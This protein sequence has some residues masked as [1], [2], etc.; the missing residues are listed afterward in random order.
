MNLNPVKDLGCN[1]WNWDLQVCL[2][3][4]ERYVFNSQGLCTPL[5]PNCRTFNTNNSCLECYKGYKISGT[6]CV[7]DEKINLPATDVGCAQWNWDSQIC[8]KC[9]VR[10][11]MNSR[12]QCIK[13]QD[14]CENFNSNG[15]CTKCYKGFILNSANQCILSLQTSPTD[16]NCK[17]WDWDN[18]ICLECSQRHVF[19]SA[20]KCKQV[21]DSC[22]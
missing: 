18:Q 10:Y 20:G 2:Q 4:S 7:L 19:D 12:G 8:T 15:I 17:L 6:T 14:D 11:M 9:S 5:D 21:N 3:C 1:D 16:K 13:Q 22:R